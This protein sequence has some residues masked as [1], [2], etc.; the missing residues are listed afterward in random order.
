MGIA[1]RTEMKG[2]LGREDGRPAPIVFPG[3]GEGEERLSFEK[4]NP[5]AFFLFTYSG[6]LFVPLGVQGTVR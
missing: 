5:E 6:A 1:W 3:C 2:C 4:V